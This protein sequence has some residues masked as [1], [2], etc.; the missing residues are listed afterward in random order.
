MYV[1]HQLSISF[2]GNPL[3]QDIGFLINPNDR[4]GLAGDNG[5]GKSTLLKMIARL[6]SYDTGQITIPSDKKVGYLP[7]EMST[8]SALSVIEETLLAFDEAKALEQRI[9]LLSESLAARDDYESDAYIKMAEQLSNANERFHMIGGHR[10][11]AEA[12][13]VLKGLGFQQSDFV[14]PL[15]TFS[16]GWQMRVEIAKLLLRKPDLLLLD[17]PVNHLDIESIEWLESFLKTYSGA[18]VLVA[19]DRRFLDTVSNRTIEISKGRIYDFKMSYSR[20]VEERI[21]R[22][23]QEKTAFD[24]QQKQIAQIERFVERF[25]YKATKAKQVKSKQK[26]LDKM[27]KVNI[28]TI[29]HSAIHFSFQEAPPSGKITL[30]CKGINKS[31]GDKQVLSAVDFVAL[32]GE[33]IAFVG[34]NGTGKSTFSKIII[35]ALDYEGHLQLGHNVKIGY[36]AQNQTDALDKDKTVF[37]TIDDV[38]VG[39]MRPKVRDIL[40]SFLFGTE[41]VDKKVKV[42]SGGEKARLALAKMLLEPYNLLLLDEPTNHLDLKSKDILKT[43]L[44]NYKG[45]LIIVSHD[46]DFLSGL[47]DKVF[48]FRHL[49]TQMVLGDVQ[50]YLNK[51]KLEHLAELNSSVAATDISKPNNEAK[52]KSEQHRAYLERKE[53]DKKLRKLK[54]QLQQEEETI[55]DLEAQIERYDAQIQ[56]GDADILSSENFFKDYNALKLL[57]EEAMERWEAFLETIEQT[58]NN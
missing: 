56:T 47:T 4:I 49:Q 14:R 15:R 53:R 26:A 10:Q 7:Q 45:T 2:N 29:D 41:D 1:I 55:A 5:S 39:D 37:E 20:Y 38:A 22:L 42:L 24:Q 35:G 11:A 3:F 32:R 27:D 13:K 50:D 54:S 57:L 17:E 16:G 19:H 34:Q 6:Q 18:L 21:Q 58:E 28:D 43:A 30:E 31:F 46:R 12:E 9:G 40:G 36:Y 44:L 52:V 23:E 33:K 8:N 51:R 25:R 48:E